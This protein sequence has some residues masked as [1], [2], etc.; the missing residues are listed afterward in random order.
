V[1]ASEALDSAADRALASRRERLRR[2]AQHLHALSPLTAF[3]RGFAVP[4]GREGRV[5][6]RVEHFPAEGEFDLIVH[7]GVVPCRVEDRAPFAR[8]DS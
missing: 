2:S 6:R 4:I 5:L 8:G 7:D 3:N 1:R